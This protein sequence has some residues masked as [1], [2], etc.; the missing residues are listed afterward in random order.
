MKHDQSILPVGMV[1]IMLPDE[2]L[3]VPMSG[4]PT[5]ISITKRGIHLKRGWRGDRQRIIE[6]L[7]GAITRLE[8]EQEAA[9]SVIH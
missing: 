3:G 6:C 4:I 7:K 9:T 5:T 8:A 1:G 2:L